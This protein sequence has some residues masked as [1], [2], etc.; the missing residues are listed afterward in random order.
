MKTGGADELRLRDGEDQN[1]EAEAEE[2]QIVKEERSRI[3]RIADIS[4]A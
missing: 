3:A 2:E 1:E 4:R